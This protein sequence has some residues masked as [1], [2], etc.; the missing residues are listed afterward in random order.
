[1]KKFLCLLL[2]LVMATTL[3]TSTAFAAD[4]PDKVTIEYWFCVGG[5]LETAVMEQVEAFN[6][7]QDEVEVIAT[8]QGYFQDCVAK[9]QA[10][11]LA[12]N[13]PV[14]TM[15]ERAVTPQFYYA[16]R[17]V[18]LAPY[19]ERDGFDLD[20][21][22][23][24]LNF[25]IYG[26]E[27]AGLP[28]TRSVPVLYYNKDAFR[29]AG[30]DPESPPTTWDE[31]LET[32]DKLTIKDGDEVT[33]Y[34]FEFSTSDITSL[35][36]YVAQTGATMLNE[37]ITGIG[38][39]DERG[40]QVFDYFYALKNSEGQKMAPVADSATVC[41][42]DFYNGTVAMIT[43]SNAAMAA[44]LQETDGQFEVGAALLP[45]CDGN[46][47][48]ATGGSNIV[49]LSGCGEEQQ[50][51]AWKF[52][53][54]LYEP[55]V[56]GQFV[57]NTGYTPL[58]EAIYNSDAVQSVIAEHPQYA[59]PFEAASYVVDPYPCENWAECQQIMTNYTSALL[60]E[61]AYTSEEALAGIAE[62]VEAVLAG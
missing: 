18:D 7:S 56:G 12:G 25:S 38:F 59:V 10:A 44:I 22:G 31:M 37:D 43:E 6:A 30:L 60:V 16:G 33:Q 13:Q 62:E 15:M 32:M 61:G 54:Y 41:K 58:T 26:D 34:G 29:A 51:A 50:E 46:F 40:L 57:V 21:F 2:C 23:K 11:I 47:A 55:E 8:F 42:Q 45:A 4:N 14:L 27:V 53:K 36:A 35:Q 20:Q 52:I 48:H 28:V 24:F 49:M 3:F 1:M 9:T 5:A 17:T 19:I 39:N